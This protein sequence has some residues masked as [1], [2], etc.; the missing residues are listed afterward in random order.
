MPAFVASDTGVAAAAG[1][2]GRSSRVFRAPSAAQQS[3]GPKISWNGRPPT[4]VMY[5]MSENPFGVSTSDRVDAG[6]LPA[7]ANT[8]CAS[9]SYEI[10]GQFV[11]VPGPTPPSSWLFTLPRIGGL[12]GD[13]AYL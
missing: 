9:G 10:P 7:C 2:G 6:T 13:G 5:L 11:A 4:P 8:T 1:A 3:P 12:K